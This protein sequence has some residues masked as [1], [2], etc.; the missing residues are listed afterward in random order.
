MGVEIN[1]P[2]KWFTEGQKKQ[3]ERIYK[4]HRLKLH[5]V[6]A[7]CLFACLNTLKCSLGGPFRKKIFLL[8]NLPFSIA[9]QNFCSFQGKSAFHI[10]LIALYFCVQRCGALYKQRTWNTGSLPS[11]SDASLSRITDTSFSEQD[12]D[13][14]R[15]LED[16]AWGLTQSF[17]WLFPL[18]NFK[19]P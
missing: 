17:A 11:T 4:G 15:L 13:F 12:V 14:H 18:S 10:E 16:Q 3:D 5:S 9:L 19:I 1:N 2:K 7:V 6:V 8:K